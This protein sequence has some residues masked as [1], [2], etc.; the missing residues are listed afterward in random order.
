MEFSSLRDRH[1]YSA[2][3][4]VG[5]FTS[6]IMQVGRV[7]STGWINKYIDETAGHTGVS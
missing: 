2:G 1:A 5:V 3:T 4:H 7:D 6:F